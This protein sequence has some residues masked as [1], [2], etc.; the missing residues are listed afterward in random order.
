MI[1]RKWLCAACCAVVLSMV[2][3][4]AQL[5]SQ[6]QDSSRSIQIA[7][8]PSDPFEPVTSQP[9]S[10]ES[11]GAKGA[12]LAL[13]RRALQ[14]S[15]FAGT[16]FP[17]TV[18]ISFTANGQVKDVGPGDME[19]TRNLSGNRR[20]KGHLG[21]FSL[22]RIITD[23]M[24]DVGSSG[25]IPF[26]LDMAREYVFGAIPGPANFIR[27]ANA[28]VNGTSVTCF[29]TSV[30]PSLS[31]RRD[32]SEAEYCIDPHSELMR[33]YSVAPG[34]YAIYGY[35]NSADFHGKTISDQ[36]VIA[37]A[38][39]VI[40]QGSISVT[41]PAS[42]DPALFT[43]TPGMSTQGVGLQPPTRRTLSRDAGNPS[44]SDSTTVQPVIVHAILS[45]DGSVFEAEAL[46]TPDAPLS[47]SAVDLVKKTKY[48][49]SIDYGYPPQQEIFVIVQ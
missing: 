43:P 20:W 34:I 23:R 46:Q 11:P 18:R 5:A 22:T 36:V 13:F 17:Y 40:L 28:T 7:L 10:V 49:S 4:V 27:T 6:V 42:L 12:I 37:E 21:S 48:D 25:P 24:Y 32:W 16:G 19:E 2:G 9:E 3:P 8:P 31:A 45:P 33:I 15:A 38:G 44:A 35:G 1:R 14:K 29:L 30:R 39:K 47:Q 26:R 41:D